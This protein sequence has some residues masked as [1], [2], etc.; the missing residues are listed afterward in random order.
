MTRGGTQGNIGKKCAAE[1][2]AKSDPFLREKIFFMSLI[3]F[4]SHTDLAI[5][6]TN[7]TE[8]RFLKKKMLIPQSCRPLIANLRSLLTAWLVEK[9]TLSKTL[10]SEIVYL[11]LF[12]G[13]YPFKPS[14]EGYPRG[15]C[16]RKS[17]SHFALS[18]TCASW[19]SGKGNG[20]FQRCLP[21]NT[22]FRGK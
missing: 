20:A 10:N 13:I 9:Y 22:L 1:A 17:R 7:I 4:V 19:T 3:R 21:F 18:R 14:K 11:T 12:S 2:F 6:Q 16:G 5:S 15:I 8:F